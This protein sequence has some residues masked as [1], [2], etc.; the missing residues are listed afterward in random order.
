MNKTFCSHFNDT[1]TDQQSFYNV[2][3]YRYFKDRTSVRIFIYK[4]IQ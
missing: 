2:C 3:I 1:A 4:K